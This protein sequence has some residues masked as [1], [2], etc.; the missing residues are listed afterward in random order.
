DDVNEQA[1]VLR[2]AKRNRM[3]RW[4]AASTAAM[5]IGLLAGFVLLPNPN[6][7][8]LADLPAIREVNVLPYVENV[9]VLRQ[10]SKAVSPD[11]MI[12]DDAAFSRQVKELDKAND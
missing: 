8:L 1:A 6:N 11:Q 3:W 9:E 4:I 7:H 10:L 12:K 2:A 5:A